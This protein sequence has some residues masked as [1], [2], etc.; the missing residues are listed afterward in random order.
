MNQDT[1]RQ[2]GP[3]VLSIL[4]I[5]AVAVVRNYSRTLAAVTATMPIAIP[6]SLWII[7]SGSKGDRR[8]V[9]EYSDAL[10]IG[11]LST[12]AFTVAVWFASRAGWKLWPMIG[13]GY[14]AWAVSLGVM[15]LVRRFF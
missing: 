6:L 14:A 12:L 1:L 2:V 9:Q 13:A 3:V 10:P 15:L 4:V 11:L 8:Q 5:I 7:Y